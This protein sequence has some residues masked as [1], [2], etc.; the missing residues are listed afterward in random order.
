VELHLLTA[1][2]VDLTDHAGATAAS[3]AL[4]RS[5][6]ADLGHR[7][8]W[9]VVLD[10]SG[11]PGRGFS[12]VDTEADTV[13][14]PRRSLGVSTAR[15]IAL[16]SAIDS[17]GDDSWVFRL[18]GDDELDVDGWH[19]LVRDPHFAM[20]AW[21]PTNLV[22]T[23]GARTAHWFD[24]MRMWPRQ[25]CVENWT[26]PMPFHPN[27]V[28]VR[29]EL[30]AVSGGWPAL[31]VNED[32]LW[33]FELNALEGGLALPHVTLR[34]RRW[35][36]QT[37]AGNDYASAKSRSFHSIAAI[38]NSRRR[39]EGLGAVSPPAPETAALYRTDQP[40]EKSGLGGPSD[41][42]GVAALPAA[43][44]TAIAAVAGPPL[45][46]TA[47][48]PG[49]AG[50]CSAVVHTATGRLFAKWVGPD[51]ADTARQ[52]LAREAANLDAVSSVVPT[53]SL[54]GLVGGEDPVLMTS[55]LD[56]GFPD[57]TDPGVLAEAGAVLDT[58]AGLP[59]DR[60]RG[61][62]GHLRPGDVAPDEADGVEWL[63]GGRVEDLFTCAAGALELPRSVLGH[64]DPHHHNWITHG[65]RLHLVDFD[66]LGP[67]PLGW[68]RVFL[69]AHV[70]GR[71]ADERADWVL[72]RTASVE[73]AQLMTGALAY[74]AARSSLHAP[75]AR[76][77]AWFAANIATACELY[78]ALSCH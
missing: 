46:V 43:V 69:A 47:C 26:S 77:R 44:V 57:W 73:T 64:T 54:L 5:A 63:L 36:G 11:E 17:G 16:G 28:V 71:P 67:V 61:Y 50:Q 33:C 12:A 37:V 35:S 72:E 30:A 56:G 65:G 41:H 40:S 60:C 42:Q 49:F 78:D 13:V 27:N 3:V 48:T 59:L 29:T 4:L 20:A 9:H 68:D 58:L 45:D 1:L 31:V 74:R 51:G 6:F 39:R 76:T 24:E 7:V 19:D 15:N 2:H 52:A 18:D 34:Y 10:G 53:A 70:T 55:H 32:L 25:S 62:R 21:H 23:D 14:R 22:T 38:V 8:R 75:E 66:H